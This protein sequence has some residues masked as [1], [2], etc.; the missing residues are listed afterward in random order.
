MSVQATFRFSSG[1]EWSYW[2]RLNDLIGVELLDSTQR[3]I[4]LDRTTNHAR[5]F[6]GSWRGQSV[7]TRAVCSPFFAKKG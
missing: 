1:S 6:V 7:A 3:S 2:A 5:G 4:T